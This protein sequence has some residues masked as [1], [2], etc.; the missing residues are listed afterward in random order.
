MMDQKVSNIIR[1]LDKKEIDFFLVSTSDEFLNE[2]VPTYNKRLQW[3]TNF[4][5]SFGIALISSNRKIFFTDGRYTLQARKEIDSSFEIYDISLQS[6]KSFLKEKIKK[7]KIILDTRT[8]SKNQ[9]IPIIDDS[10]FSQNE[11]IHDTY[12]IIDTLWKRRKTQNKNFFLLSPEK[13]GF[14]FEKKLKLISK[15]NKEKRILVLTSPESICWLLNIRGYDLDFTP[16][17]MSRMIIYKEKV[18]IFIS[19]KNIPQSFHSKFKDKI[20]IFDINK[21]EESLSKLDSQKVFADIQISYYLYKVIEKTNSNVVYGRDFCKILKSQKNNF[22]IKASKKAHIIDGVALIKFFYWL[23][24]NFYKK[25]MT[26]YYVAE[27]LKSL[28]KE[29]KEYFSL[30]FPT[31]AASAGNASII[32][33]I[34]NKESGYIKN[35]KIFLC[36]SGAQYFGATTDITR[37][38]FLGKKN[39]PKLIKEIFTMVLA[40]HINISIAKFPVGTKGYQLDSIARY[41]LWRN[42]LDYNHGTGHGVGSFLGVHE[43]PQSISKSFSD[44]ELKPGMILSNEPGYYEDK[45]FGIRTENLVLVKKSDKNRFL[46]F[47]TLSLCPYETRLIDKN[48]LEKNQIRWINNYHCKLYKKISPYLSNEEKSWLK[49]KTIPI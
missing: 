11:Y 32:H 28:R 23:D 3:L 31:I 48:L 34:P 17:I 39:P 35:N 20:K 4:S 26:E 42:G 38:I 10:K 29:S 30:S 47:E 33:Y 15:F 21:F 7:K 46:E 12:N 6:L 41:E 49:L 8:F 24:K 27:K 9:L 13:S 36:D 44:F 40:G 14:S 45:K 19:K 16:I 43:G 25:K 5:G 2:Y 22:E 18:E 37:T 1:F